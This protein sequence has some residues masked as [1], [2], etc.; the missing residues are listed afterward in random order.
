MPRSPGTLGLSLAVAAL[1]VLGGCATRLD[2][3]PLAPPLWED[4][5]SEHVTEPPR[6]YYSPF[7]WDTVDQ[8]LF[9]PVSRVLAVDT[10]VPAVNVNAMDEVPDSSWFTN[11][12]GA[13]EG[14]TVEDSRRG[15]CPEALLT[16]AGPWV[17]TAAKPD[18]ANPGFIIRGDDGNGYLLKM[19]GGPTAGERATAADVVGSRVYQAVGFHAPC[20]TV[21]FF[22]P[23]ILALDPEATTSDPRGNKLPMTREDVEQVLAKALVLPDGRLRASA[24]LFLSGR[25]IGPWTYQGTRPDDPNDVVRHEDRRDL[26]GARVLAAWLNHFDAREQNTLAMWV[27]EDGRSFVRHHYIDFGDCFGS[28]WDID[29]LSRRFGHSHYLHVGHVLGDLFTF[30]AISRPWDEVTVS[31]IA[32]ILGYFDAQHFEPRAWKAG[33]PNPAFARMRDEDGAWMAR[34]LAHVTDEH[35]VAMLGE[36][37]MSDEVAE[38]ELLRTLIARRD[39]ILDE[40]L[41]VRSPLAHFEVRSREGREEVCFTDLALGAGVTDPRQVHV[42]SRMYYGE[43]RQP[44]WE[45]HET[46][47]DGAAAARSCVALVEGESRPSRR[48]G[49]AARDSVDRYAILDLR[50]H[51]MAGQEPLPPA[52]LHFYDLGDDGFQLVAVE[53]PADDQPPVHP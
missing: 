41:R 23:E 7:A 46:V 24:S 27:E 31:R 52:R 20:N 18:G 14:W 1:T 5:D 10:I 17:V 33:Y 45:R 2:R 16:P 34:I 29:P 37:R 40:Y 6:E 8:T 11:R 50:V 25:P 13:G 35:V 9:R 51:T 48:H 28:R 3:Y 30:G 53:R 19:D 26:R 21:V 42:E 4:P 22:D 44:A 47:T 49:R 15:S 43:F 32:P 36:A 12:I 39:K 38:R